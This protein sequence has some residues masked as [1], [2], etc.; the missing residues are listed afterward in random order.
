MESRKT[1]G[2]RSKTHRGV[3]EPRHLFHNG[4]WCTFCFSTLYGKVIIKWKDTI[5]QGN[6][7]MEFQETHD[8]I[9]TTCVLLVLV[10]SFDDG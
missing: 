9:Q 5:W 10:G 3:M 2:Q 1:V 6:N 7:Q 8:K 4:E